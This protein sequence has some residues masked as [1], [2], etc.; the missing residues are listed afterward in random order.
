MRNHLNNIFKVI[1]DYMRESWKDQ[2]RVNITKL[3]RTA[4]LF[5]QDSLSTFKL[6]DIYSMLIQARN[7]EKLEVKE[8]AIDCS[9]YLGC[10]I[11]LDMI[12]DNILPFISTS[13]NEESI[14]NLTSI[15]ILLSSAI[16][17][18][19]RNDNLITQI[20][21]ICS[22]LEVIDITILKV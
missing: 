16:K 5:A 8:A 13:N 2:Q 21:R 19:E 3:L 14:R 6:N 1:L 18:V 20:E 12:L 7:D 9:M 11:K 4:I 10:F 17:G 15:I 22:A